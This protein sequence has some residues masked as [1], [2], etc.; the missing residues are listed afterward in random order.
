MARLMSAVGF[1]IDGI[2][3]ELPEPSGDATVIHGIPV[4]TSA[5]EGRA[6]VVHQFE[7]LFTIEPGDVLVTPSTTEAFNSMIHLVGAIVTDHGSYACHSAI[8]ARELGFPAVVGTTN[9][10]HRIPHGARIRVD[11]R[12]GEVT[13]LG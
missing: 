11:G 1:M 13:V 12:T 10:S 4:G 9:G 6:H 5:Y 7:D 8:M 3:G 2:L